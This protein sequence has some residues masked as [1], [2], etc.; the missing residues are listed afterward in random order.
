MLLALISLWETQNNALPPIPPG[1][2]PPPFTGATPQSL[3]IQNRVTM[4]LQQLQWWSNP[5]PVRDAIIG[6]LS[7]AFGWAYSLVDYA[8][9][10]TR[11]ATST[12][13]F[14]DLW[15]YDYLALTC[16]RVSG[17]PDPAYATRISSTVT[18]VRG[19][20]PGM[21]EAITILTGIPPII[22]E[23]F[24]GGDT[25]G[26]NIACGWDV[27]GGW[28]S[29]ILPCQVFIIATVGGVGVGVANIG[30]WS[31]GVGSSATPSWLGWDNYGSWISQ[32]S[33][34]GQVTPQDLIDVIN[35]TKPEG[36]CVWLQI[37]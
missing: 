20:R 23:P 13:F 2:G 29:A 27:A 26:W 36:V 25:G 11:L 12:S 35:L 3:S 37:L 16:Q 17:E 14:I 34:A 18:Q 28:G 1:P 33:I 30:G 5:A 31:S 15:A 4:L 7:D 21:V 32:A 22:F 10:Q 24:N 8:K 19:S 6:G 9:Q